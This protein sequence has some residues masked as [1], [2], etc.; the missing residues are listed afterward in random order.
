MKKIINGKL[1]DTDTAKSIG[2]YGNGYGIGDYHYFYEVLYRKKTGEFFLYGSGGAGTRYSVEC[3]NRCWT[4]GDAIIPFTE[5]EA[6]EW[7]E[8]HLDA[9]DYME[10]F[11]TVEE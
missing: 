6:K 5:D 3:G 9:D 8:E 2:S 10:V 4:G 1:Y 11:G 7:A